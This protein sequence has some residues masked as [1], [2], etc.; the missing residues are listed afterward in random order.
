MRIYVSSRSAGT[1][2]DGGNILSFT[3]CAQVLQ[4]DNFTQAKGV[5]NREENVNST[6]GKSFPQMTSICLLFPDVYLNHF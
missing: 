4:S 2:V 3:P 5:P 1:V 6:P